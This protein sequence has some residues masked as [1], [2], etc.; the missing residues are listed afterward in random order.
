MNQMPNSVTER[1]SAGTA[2][3]V[4]SAILIALAPLPMGCAGSAQMG[5]A[6][7]VSGNE[8]GGK[9]PYAEGG[10][11]AAGDAARAHCSQFGR[12]RKSPKCN[13]P[14]RAEVARLGFSAGNRDLRPGRHE[15]R[16]SRPRTAAQCVG[17][18]V[19][20]YP[21]RRRRMTDFTARSI[22]SAPN[23]DRERRR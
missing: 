17:L 15:S 19:C 1:A 12:K 18:R 9:V 7:A 3:A 6:P 13:L 2:R 4:L 16:Q 8:Q 14:R 10:M 20:R 22:R 21:W 11:Q 5:G 23:H